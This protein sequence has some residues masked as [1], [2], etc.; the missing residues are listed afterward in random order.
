M[1]S[2]GSKHTVIVF[3]NVCTKGCYLGQARCLYG[4]FYFEMC[5][6]MFSFIRALAENDFGG[7]MFGT[8]EILLQVRAQS[9]RA[10]SE[11]EEVRQN[12]AR[13]E[14]EKAVLEER[15]E[16]EGAER[17]T[18]VASVSHERDFLLRQASVSPQ[19]RCCIVS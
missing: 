15:V 14:T 6:P 3:S 10:E 17:V 7:T 9:K 16:V 11:L 18:V 2:Q 19:R 4:S 13:I 8:H 1:I 5:L 12:T